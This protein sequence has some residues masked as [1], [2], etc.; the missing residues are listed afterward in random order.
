MPVLFS[1]PSWAV[2]S[3]PLFHCWC[4]VHACVFLPHAHPLLV[5][6]LFVYWRREIIS[7]WCIFSSSFISRCMA[8]YANSNFSPC[9]SQLLVSMQ[10]SYSGHLHFMTTPTHL[11]FSSFPLPRSIWINPPSKDLGVGQRHAG[12]EHR[13]RGGGSRR[14]CSGKRLWMNILISLL[15]M[16][17]V[18]G[19]TGIRRDVNANI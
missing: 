13:H 2:G 17:R 7:L 16:N 9:G 4:S 3:R 10:V 5:F 1:S 18:V 12:P 8:L 6:L 15:L 19:K 14:R 11:L